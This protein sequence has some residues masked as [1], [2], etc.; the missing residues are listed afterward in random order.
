MLSNLYLLFATLHNLYIVICICAHGPYGLLHNKLLTLNRKKMGNTAVSDIESSS[1]TR[2]DK[3]GENTVIL[4][5]STQRRIIHTIE[6]NK[7]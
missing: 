3:L 4:L 6:T 2:C 5:E 1:V 7:F